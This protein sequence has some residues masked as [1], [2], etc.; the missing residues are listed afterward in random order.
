MG[1]REGLEA[2][3]IV[4]ILITYL[5]KNDQRSKLRYIWQ[6]VTAA[7]LLSFGL[8]AFFTTSSYYLPFTEQEILGGALSILTVALI[9]WMIFWLASHAKSLK[10]ELQASVDKALATSAVALVLVSFL[11]VAREGL[12]TALFVWTA[13]LATDETA[14]PLTGVLLGLATAVG[15]GFLI[16]KGAVRINLQ[17]FFYYTG[18]GLIVVAAGVLSY[19]IHDFQEAGV[20]PGEDIRAFDISNVIAPDGWFGTI[21]RGT[22]NFTPNPSTLQSVIWVI[23]LAPTLYLFHTKTQTATRKKGKSHA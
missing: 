5:V 11:A 8:G 15:I 6:G 18:I 9:T 14:T 1:L 10:G 22:I 20:L 21:L 19:G 2:A 16:Y 23:Y 3:L 12:E 7:A 13:I 17:K 4:T